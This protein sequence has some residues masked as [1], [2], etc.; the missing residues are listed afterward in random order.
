MTTFEK[1]RL[2]PEAFKTERNKACQSLA[3]EFRQ[4]G[5]VSN[6]AFPSFLKVFATTLL[7]PDKTTLFAFYE[8]FKFAETRA[9]SGDEDAKRV[10][11]SV[12]LCVED[13]AASTDDAPVPDAVDAGGASV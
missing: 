8:L 6:D 5:R 11:S 3:K 1:I 9:L 10:V 12:C 2:L 7:L 13:V 4:T